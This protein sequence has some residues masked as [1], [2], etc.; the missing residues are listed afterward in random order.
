MCFKDVGEILEIE[1][2][3]ITNTYVLHCDRVLD[4]QGWRLSGNVS[5]W[6]NDRG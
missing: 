3:V 1:C 4:P 2:D 5:Y 6:P